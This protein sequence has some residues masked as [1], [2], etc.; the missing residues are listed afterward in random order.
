DRHPL[1]D[2]LARDLLEDPRAGAVEIDVNGGLVVG[3]VEARPRVVDA[4][5]RQYDLALD[6]HGSAAAPGEEGAAERDPAREARF[7]RARVL[8]DH[9]DLEAGRPAENV[10][11][12]RGVLDAWQLDDDAIG[13]LLLDDRLG[14]AELVDAIAQDRDVLLDCAVL[15]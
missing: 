1:A 14:D 6:E 13:A 11:R 10:L 15:D 9:A 12:A 7:R 4:G 8:V 3:R 5:S 2:V